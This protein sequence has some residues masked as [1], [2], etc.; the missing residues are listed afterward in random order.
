[1]ALW[2]R[3]IFFFFLSEI[4]HNKL[5][6]VKV[7][8]F[9]LF[10]FFF[11]FFFYHW[12]LSA[13]D[14]PPFRPSLCHTTGFRLPM[15]LPSLSLPLVPYLTSLYF[16]FYLVDIRSINWLSKGKA[17]NSNFLALPY[18]LFTRFVNRQFFFWT[19]CSLLLVSLICLGFSIDMNHHCH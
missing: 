19:L 2:R 7:M 3:I 15:G 11:F 14:L 1:M 4:L 6:I 8:V 10:F 12:E 16:W 5:I 9:L 17:C 13:F 18:K